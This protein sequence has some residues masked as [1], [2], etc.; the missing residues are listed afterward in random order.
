[1]ILLTVRTQSQNDGGHTRVIFFCICSKRIKYA[2]S[3]M[4]L[5]YFGKVEQVNG[6]KACNAPRTA[7]GCLVLYASLQAHR[8]VYSIKYLHNRPLRTFVVLLLQEI[9]MFFAI[10]FDSK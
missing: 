10:K 9:F 8:Y 2:R 6:L 4:K 5:H 1:M 7:R 3:I